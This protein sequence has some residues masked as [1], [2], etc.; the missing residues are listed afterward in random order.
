MYDCRD[1]YYASPQRDHIPEMITLFASPK[2]FTDPHIAMIQRNAIESWIRLS[3]RPDII[4]FG[5]EDGVA[6]VAQ[7]LEVRH[8]PHVAR[9]EFGTPLLN[10]VFENAERIATTPFQC[11]INAD[12]ILMGD[13]M[14]AVEFTARRKKR[15]LL[16]GRTHDVAVAE[17]LTFKAG[18]DETL[19]ERSRTEGVLRSQWACDYFVFSRWLWPRLPAFAVGR[20]W[21]DNALLHMA[22]RA[23]ASLIDATPS[24]TAI[25]QR[26]GYSGA[27]GGEN[28]LANPEARRNILLAGGP[29]NM[30]NWGDAQYRLVDGNLRWSWKG[31]LKGARL[32]R[33]LYLAFREAKLRRFGRP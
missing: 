13:F 1:D 33:G 26:H 27:L 6:D 18:W 21:F 22:R 5:D 7:E 14:S 15:F 8:C 3:P 20:C 11:Y 32:T 9:N 31:Y 16:G 4:L 23:R 2:A 19:R 25:H 28:Y 29:Q 24:V 30:C 10:D 12:I 17:N